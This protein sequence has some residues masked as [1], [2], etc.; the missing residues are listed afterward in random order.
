MSRVSFLV[1]GGVILVFVV[2]FTILFIVPHVRDS[3]VPFNTN[4]EF[5]EETNAAVM[6]LVNLKL[7]AFYGFP[8]R[9]LPEGVFTEELQQRIE[10]EPFF[11][12]FRERSRLF[13]YA[14]RNYMSTLHYVA[15][16]DRGEK[17][18][19]VLVRVYEGLLYDPFVRI[20]WITI[21]RREDGSY[22]IYDIDYDT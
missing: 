19:L 7:T 16:N 18:L 22:V 14:D 4:R 17:L 8:S 15:E 6:G 2:A 9:N 5:S 13:W 20:H 21:M 1:F 3:Q 11:S 12:H 10:T